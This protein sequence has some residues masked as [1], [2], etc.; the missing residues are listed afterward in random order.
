M[1]L[2]CKKKKRYF[3][4]LFLCSRNCLILVDV[5]DGGLNFRVDLFDE[6]AEPVT[7]KRRGRRKSWD[8]SDESER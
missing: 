3:N 4:I 7:R 6:D 5:K 2:N 1:K 8:D